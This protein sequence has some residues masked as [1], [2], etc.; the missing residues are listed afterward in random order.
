VSARSRYTGIILCF[1]VA[2]A[3]GACAG[4][5]EPRAQSVDPQPTEPCHAR[6]IVGFVAAADP[7]MIAALAQ[8][9]GVGLAVVSL[10]RPDL[11]V[12]DLSMPTVDPSCRAALERLRS[13]PRVR[14]ADLDVRRFPQ[15]G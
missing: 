7:P 15:Q 12:L 4:P 8:A 14:S 5:G 11:Y 2:A 13:D 3:A 10:L 9:H 1:V 6:I